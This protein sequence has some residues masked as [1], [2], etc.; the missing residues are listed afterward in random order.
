MSEN[1]EA[2]AQSIAIAADALPDEKR[3]FLMGYAEGVIAMA[4]SLRA[5]QRESA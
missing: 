3:E 1:R 4:A 2:V 5:P